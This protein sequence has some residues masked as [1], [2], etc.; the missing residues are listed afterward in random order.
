MSGNIR[1]EAQLKLRN[2]HIR[3][4]LAA[5]KWTNADLA[6]AIG[7]EQVYVG[8]IV[9]MRLKNFRLENR[10]GKIAVAIST[11]LG[12]DLDDVIPPV[13]IG[14][15]IKEAR[16]VGEVGL[17]QLES[18]SGG[19]LL[20]QSD[21]GESV[22][23]RL[24]A[25]QRVSEILERLEPRDADVLRMRFGIDGDSKTLRQVGKKLKTSCE[26]ARQIE[27]RAI[28]EAGRALRDTAASRLACGCIEVD[29]LPGLEAEVAAP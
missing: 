17:Q 8:L 12:L 15:D 5:R 7:A 19:R 25:K 10:L 1:V 29:E 28:R 20:V 11:T 3:E 24:D 27:T 23:R 18:M 2:G 9:N 13:L 6:R 4:A 22:D 16:A 26:R 14:K 21:D